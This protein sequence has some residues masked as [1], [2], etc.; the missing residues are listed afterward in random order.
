MKPTENVEL[1]LKSKRIVYQMSQEL[2]QTNVNHDFHNALLSLDIPDLDKKAGFDGYIQLQ[3]DIKESLKNYM[4]NGKKLDLL[5][6]LSGQQMKCVNQMLNTIKSKNPS[7]PK[8]SKKSENGEYSGEQI[9]AKN[10]QIVNVERDSNDIPRGPIPFGI[11]PLQVDQFYKDEEMEDSE[12]LDWPNSQPDRSSSRIPDIPM[13]P[14]PISQSI[15]ISEPV[16]IVKF[17]ELQPTKKIISRSRPIEKL[18]AQIQT[19]EVEEEVQ[20][21]ERTEKITAEIGTNC[22]LLIT[23]RVEED[24]EPVSRKST[25]I[26]SP[27]STV[28]SDIS[29]GEVVG[30]SSIRN[31]VTVRTDGSIVPTPRVLED[32]D[33]VAS[34]ILIAK[35][36]SP[37]GVAEVDM[38]ISS[39]HS[40]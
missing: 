20:E 32:D 1:D 11:P 34:D 18:D 37:F 9:V 8:D 31:V 10:I 24:E 4:K 33:D 7:D 40:H 21:T 29:E 26:M 28:P 15:R 13:E 12:Y 5:S 3:D 17:E 19:D 39:A 22:R 38:S 16:K 14:V 36:S 23:P 2:E 25:P 30:F 27:I 6:L 35:S